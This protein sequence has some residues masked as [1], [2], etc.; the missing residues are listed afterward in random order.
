MSDAMRKY[1]GHASGAKQ[2]G[3]PF[4]LSFAEWME[5]WNQSGKWEQRGKCVGQYVMARHGDVGPYSEANVSII[6]ASQNVHDANVAP[7]DPIPYEWVYR[8]HSGS[9]PYEARLFGQHIG[10]FKTVTEAEVYTRWAFVRLTFEPRAKDS[11]P[12]TTTEA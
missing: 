8:P 7:I 9:K 4:L 10:F 1:R 2:R 11:T 12:A 6:L 3:I 5:I